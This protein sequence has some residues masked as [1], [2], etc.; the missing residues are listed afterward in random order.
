M[1]RL[2]ILTLTFALICINNTWAQ[3]FFPERGRVF[4]DSIVPKIYIAI[5]PDSLQAIFN[6]PSSNYE[7][8]AQFVFNDGVHIDTVYNIGFRLRGN[9]SRSAQKKSFKIS[10]NTFVKGQSYQKLDKLNLNGEHNDPSIARSKTY[11]DANI[12]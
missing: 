7:Y 10:F 6:N 4:N 2:L 5:N 3:P 9:T 12:F 11:W 1:S 8:R